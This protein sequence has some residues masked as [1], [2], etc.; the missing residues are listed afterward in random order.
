MGWRALATR[1]SD[2]SAGVVGLLK[3]TQAQPPPDPAQRCPARPRAGTWKETVP[4]GRA[5]RGS[6]PTTPAIHARVAGS[7]RGAGSPRPAPVAD[8]G[9][10]L[11]VLADVPLVQRELVR[12]LLAVVRRARAERGHAVDHVLDQVEAV[13]VVAHH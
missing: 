8:L 7:S 1:A 5:I 2:Q 13:E 6:K 3:R 4:S 11:P 12:H 9:H 10:V